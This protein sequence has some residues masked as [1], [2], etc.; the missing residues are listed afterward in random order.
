M[1][2]KKI[3]SYT[4][5]ALHKPQNTGVKPQTEE[6]DLQTKDTKDTAASQQ[7]RVQLSDASKELA[8]VKKVTMEREDIRSEKVEPLRQMIQNDTYP[9]EPE[10][11]AGKLLDEMW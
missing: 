11:I 7:D 6:K 8:Q 10:K 2:I 1:E 3:A 4:Q 5:Q 9:I